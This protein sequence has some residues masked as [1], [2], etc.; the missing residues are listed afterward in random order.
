MI[1]NE[2]AKYTLRPK[3]TNPSNYLK[4][5]LNILKVFMTTQRIVPGPGAYEIKTSLNEKGN[6]FLSKYRGSMA[7]TIDPPQSMRFKDF[8]CMI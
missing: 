6:Y 8:S 3:T 2:A 7:T 1:G 4:K 5:L